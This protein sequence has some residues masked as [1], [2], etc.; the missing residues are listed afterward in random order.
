MTD[1]IGFHFLLIPIEYEIVQ[2]EEMTVMVVREEEMSRLLC[3]GKSRLVGRRIG[4]ASGSPQLLPESVFAWR[5][6]CRI[7]VG[8]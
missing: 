6:L 8:D 4:T 1:C 7:V 3:F 5:G 2:T